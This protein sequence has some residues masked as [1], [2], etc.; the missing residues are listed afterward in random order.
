MEE[1]NGKLALSQSPYVLMPLL[2]LLWGS[3]AAVSKLVLAKLDSYQVLFYMNG[4][5]VIVFACIVPFKVRWRALAAW[6]RMDFALLAGCGLFAFLYDFLYLQ[7]FERIPAVEASMLNYL[8]PI[9]IVLFAIP[10]NGEKMNRY[11]LLSVLMGFAGTVLLMT[12]GDLAAFKLTNWVGDVLAILAAVSWGLFTNLVKK[13]E[14][15]MLISTFLITVVAFVLSAAGMLA[16]SRLT[17]P[18]AADFGGVFWLSMSN[19]VLGFFLYFR[20]L[21]YSPASLIASFT[22]FTPF[23][24]LLFIVLL[25]DER[26]TLMDGIAAMLIL[27]SVPVQKLGTVLGAG[28]K[29]EAL[30]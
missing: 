2:L 3:V 26:L 20:A 24:T 16:Y 4:I 6:K 21:R 1:R 7:A 14:K 28:R 17:L 5:G 30:N 27:S 9:F 23:I 29:K 12:K 22:F 13:N 10:M 25:L 18:S 15:D 11:K 8:F 19:I